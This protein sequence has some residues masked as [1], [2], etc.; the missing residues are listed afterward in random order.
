VR[1]RYLHTVD[2]VL[3]PWH[4]AS[5]SSAGALRIVGTN[6]IIDAEVLRADPRARVITDDPEAVCRVLGIRHPDIQIEKGV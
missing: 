3:D 2:L 1:I 5:K 4:P 6:L